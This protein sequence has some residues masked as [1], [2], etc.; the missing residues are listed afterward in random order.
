MVKCK[1]LSLLKIC[2]T[3]RSVRHHYRSTTGSFHSRTTCTSS[4]TNKISLS[5]W[6]RLKIKSVSEGRIRSKYS[7]NHMLSRISYSKAIGSRISQSLTG[8]NSPQCKQRRA[9]VTGGIT[10]TRNVSRWIT[11]MIRSPQIFVQKNDFFHERNITRVRGMSRRVWV[12]SRQLTSHMPHSSPQWEDSFS[13]PMKTS[14]PHRERAVWSLLEDSKR[15]F[16]WRNGFSYLEDTFLFCQENQVM[17]GPEW[18]ASSTTSSKMPLKGLAKNGQP[19]KSL[20]AAASMNGSCK[21][22]AS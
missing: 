21:G 10:W 15:M 12:S 9:A 18:T 17:S 4:F 20:P 22:T 7:T 5:F 6:V 3:T 13:S 14:G 2:Q 19:H 1:F 8:W 11:R 16:L